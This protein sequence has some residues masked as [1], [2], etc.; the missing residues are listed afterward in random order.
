M[1]L[2]FSMLFLVFGFQDESQYPQPH[3]SQDRVDPNKLVQLVNQ[4]RSQGQNCGGTHMPSVGP[5]TWNDQ[6][7]AA[8][9]LHTDDMVNQNYFEHQS[10][11]GRDP[12]KR[13]EDQGYSWSTYGENIA[14]GYNDESAVIAGWLKSPGHCRNLMN[15]SLTEMGVGRNGDRWTQ[16]LARPMR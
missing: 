16:V 12:G 10:L 8:A 4:A 2:L 9:Q 11:D 1:T 3:T 15:G 14:D 7:A 5:V 13:I 6:L